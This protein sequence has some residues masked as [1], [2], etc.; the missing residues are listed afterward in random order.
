MPPHA[1]GC[2][3]KMRQKQNVVL[4]LDKRVVEKSRELGFNLSKT[5]EDHLKQLIIHFQNINGENN[6]RNNSGNDLL[7]G[8]PDLNRG[9]ESPSLI[10]WTKLADSPT[11]FML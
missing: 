2:K 9:H 11:C 7:W 5:C 6:S 4:Y 8:C 1:N 3:G 10:A